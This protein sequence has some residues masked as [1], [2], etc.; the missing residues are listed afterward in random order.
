MTINSDLL[1][2]GYSIQ[3]F[4]ETSF[5]VRAVGRGKVKLPRRGWEPEQY[6]S[7]LC[8]IEAAK[9]RVIILAPIVGPLDGPIHLQS[10]FEKPSQML[11]LGGGATTYHVFC[12]EEQELAIAELCGVGMVAQILAARERATVLNSADDGWEYQAEWG[13]IKRRHPGQDSFQWRP[14]IA[15]LRSGRK[16]RNED[17]KD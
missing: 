10:T 1:P 17:R 3:T 6:S 12:S 15:S 7:W 5:G 13:K 11:A 8:K 9:E 4:I 16:E 2:S 14:Y